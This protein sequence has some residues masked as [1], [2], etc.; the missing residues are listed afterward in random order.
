MWAIAGAAVLTGTALQR[1]CGMGTGLVVAPTLAA[2]FGGASGVLMSNATAIVSAAFI[3]VTLRAR[4][5][6]RRGATIVAW[7]I[8]GA[9]L[10]AILVRNVDPA[11][12]TIFVGVVVL[13]AL[14]NSYLRAEFRE[15]H[16]PLLTAAAGATGG[17]FNTAA[18]QA[19]PAMML[20]ARATRWEQRSFSATL[21]LIFLGMNILSVTFKS[22]IGI[23][24]TAL[25][26]VWVLPALA[27]L[28]LLG[29]AIGTRLEKRVAPHTARRIA[30]VLSMLGAILAIARGVAGL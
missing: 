28:V 24:A 23:G 14:A 5:D 19:A 7:A 3:L 29:I 16:S 21:Q 4:V 1:L 22:A 12:L 27:V 10:G 20:Y 13:L 25:P 30:E 8:P 11:W 2:L 6:W 18:G 26:P 15:R 17:F 9:L